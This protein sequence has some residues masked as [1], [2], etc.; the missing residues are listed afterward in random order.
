[1]RAKLG[2]SPI[3]W[4]NDDLVELS[5]DVSLE[6]CLRQSRSAGF[7]GMEKGRRFP[8]DPDVMLP[9]LRAADVTLCGGWFSGTLVDEDLAANKDRIAPMIELFKAVNA[10]CIVYGEVG[11]S[12]Q[13]DR[14][15]PLATKPKLC[16]DEMQ[17]YAQKVTAFGEWCAAEGMPLSYHHHMAAVVETEPELDAF[18][19]ALGAG[20]SAA[21][22]CGTP[23]VRR[24]RCAAGDRQSPRT[25]YA[26]ACEGHAPAGGR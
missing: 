3:A 23:G 2:M 8:D 17:A 10:P 1:M 12:I 24:R 9:I 5:D 22:R 26:C 14:S 18:M 7:T 4:W 19:A 11:R 20:H 25:H 13:G 15:K 21:A 16:D 6:E